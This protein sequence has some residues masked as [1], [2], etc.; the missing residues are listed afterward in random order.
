MGRQIDGACNRFEAAWKS[1]TPPRLEDYVADWQN[2]KRLVLLRE[3]VLID[4]DYRRA[5]GDMVQPQD[6][7]GRF[8]ELDS[9]WLAGI[10]LAAGERTMAPEYLPVGPVAGTRIGP[11]KLLQQIGQGGMGTVWMAEQIENVKRKVAVKLIKPGMDSG[12]VLARFEAER[13]ALALMDHP[14]IAKVLDAGT[15][16][17]GS[18][19]FVMELVKGIPMTKYCDEHQLTPRE[20]LELFVPVC[21]ALQHAH[22]KGIIHRDIKP[23]NVLV[24]SYDGRPV[25]K[26]IDFGVA[27][28]TG[29]TLTER[30]LF[31]GFGGIVGTLEYMSPEQ[32]E[33]NALDIDT[34]SDIYGLGVLLYELLT[35]TT[36]LT[37]KR[38]TQAALDEA[39]RLIREEEPPKPSTRLS[40][41]HE[42]LP[43]IASRRKM[44]A[45]K[46][47]KLVRGDLDWLVMKALEKD[48]NRRYDTA[49][50]LAADV[51]RYLNDEPVQACPPSPWYRFRKAARRNKGK[52]AILA[53]LTLALAVFAGGVGWVL[54]ERA[55][56]ASRTASEVNLVLDDV[57]GLEKEKKW[58]EALAAV[59]RAEGL[60][61]GGQGSEELQQR[62]ATA[63]AAVERGLRQ[64][65]ADQK[66]VADLA[67]IRFKQ[68]DTPTGIMDPQDANAGFG[69]AFREYGI[70]IDKLD[71]AQ[72]TAAIRERALAPELTAV[73]D[74]WTIM[75]KQAEPG[76]SGWRHLLA[77]AQRC[78]DDPVRN[79]VRAA[80]AGGEKVMLVKLA[81]T[82]D[83]AVLPASTVQLMADAL[84]SSGAFDET[85]LLLQKAQPV[86]PNDFWINYELGQVLDHNQQPRQVEKALTYYM[87]A[88]ALRKTPGLFHRLGHG[89]T[90]LGRF[91]EANAFFRESVRLW[92][93]SW[94]TYYHAAAALSNAGRHPEALPYF[95][96]AVRIRPHDC[97]SHNNLA[98]SL[99]WNGLVEEAIVSFQQAL[100]FDPNHESALIGLAGCLRKAGR[101]DE[102]IPT[103]SQLIRR[104]PE[105]F[106]V[107]HALAEA[108]R[109]DGKAD[110]AVAI[111]GPIIALRTEAVQREPQS[112]QKHKELGD[113]LR[114]G[115]RLDDAIAAYRAALRLQPDFDRAHSMMGQ[116]LLNKGLLDDAIGAYEK[117]IELQ[118]ASFRAPYWELGYTLSKKGRWAE[119]LAIFRQASKNS[120]DSVTEL[121]RFAILRSPPDSGIDHLFLAIC[122]ASR[123]EQK[124]ASAAYE[125]GVHWLEEHRPNDPDLKRFRAEAVE[126]LK[127]HEPK[128]EEKKGQSIEPGRVLEISRRARE[129]LAKV[130][131]AGR[132]EGIRRNPHNLD[133]YYALAKSLRDE[134]KMDESSA[135]LCQAI[136]VFREVVGLEPDDTGKRVSFGAALRL[137]GRPDEAIAACREAIAACREPLRLKPDIGRAYARIGH[138]YMDKGDLGQAIAAYE[139]AVDLMP[140]HS[141]SRWHFGYALS[142]KGQV[143]RA[144]VV[145]R[146]AVKLWP[147]DYTFDAL[148]YTVLKS[149]PTS[150]AE[151]LMLAMAYWRLG[152][153]AEAS[154]SYAKAVEWMGQNQVNDAQ[155]ESFRA[156]AA[157][158]LGVEAKQSRN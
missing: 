42:T 109:D 82:S 4:A 138:A 25:P 67:E 80:L 149:P 154:A 128:R 94:Y 140:Y 122:Y 96:E 104:N 141:E 85:A 43:A 88:L 115:G 92:P 46:L 16:A 53:C 106:Q 40:E 93:D 13:Q 150:G 152:H 71:V 89:L 49:S 59:N 134:G 1:G 103:L 116:A 158:V 17:S 155:L 60:F 146:Q 151:H 55:G 68:A 36:P 52:L 18:P 135:V 8:P 39:M 32:A 127:A 57:A 110:E 126:V 117:A 37:R 136:T 76:K 29:Q 133:A 5:H 28:A 70:D 99:S 77:I 121:L 111:Y 101:S 63:R 139:K 95:T 62:V 153:K 120:A 79:Q 44:E 98:A 12:Q 108:L 83:T 34:R 35:G 81:S 61:A 72:A 137:S 65:R 107:Y 15:T 105:A 24:A 124:K 145:Y 41:S 26:V 69:E 91:E 19:F 157:E 102:V 51:D 33:F 31:T 113:A 3:L 90:H 23:T 27:K 74:Y 20:R 119:A 45:A 50:A 143:R 114:H 132:R 22:Q 84:R 87:A 47:T 118:P 86:H 7:L 66:M 64:A 131:I 54:Q 58:P 21:H 73:L 148:R 14:N 48:R 123:G 130:I 38:L 9:A 129:E 112:A 78:D 100:H 2:D 147:V 142:K 11:Y 144:V 56:R 156:E 30:T 10:V 97:Q 6:Y 75:R 125:E